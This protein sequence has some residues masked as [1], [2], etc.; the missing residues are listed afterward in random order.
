M[1]RQKHCSG[2]TRMAN[3]AVVLAF[4]VGVLVNRRVQ[5]WMLKKVKRPRNYW[6]GI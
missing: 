4:S 5:G 6:I 3:M 2:L 1:L